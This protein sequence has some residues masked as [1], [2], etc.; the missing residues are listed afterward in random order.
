MR[1]F[2]RFADSVAT[3]PVPPIVLFA[4]LDDHQNLSAHMSQSSW[5]M[6]GSKMSIHL[7]AGAARS[8]G[9]KFGFEAAIL[10]IPLSVEEVVTE[11]EPPRRKVWSTTGEPNLWVIGQYSMGF[12][13][14]PLDEGCRLRVFI[15]YALPE[16]GLPHLLGLLL[17]D[18]YAKW[19]SRRMVADARQHFSSRAGAKL[20]LTH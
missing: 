5:M 1:T 16:A 15:D 11:R 18:T 14:E 19:C 2:P 4:F 3:A 7:D 12:E 10:G 20:K 13:I 6:L 9:S 17:A 8:V